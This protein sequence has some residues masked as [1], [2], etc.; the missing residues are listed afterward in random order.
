[1]LKSSWQKREGVEL[2]ET[3]HKLSHKFY[4]VIKLHITDGGIFWKLFTFNEDPKKYILNISFESYKRIH[5]AS[6]THKGL[7]SKYKKSSIHKVKEM[8]LK[9]LK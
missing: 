2:T 3:S 7:R 6:H 1:L 4:Q 5:G 8:C 9:S